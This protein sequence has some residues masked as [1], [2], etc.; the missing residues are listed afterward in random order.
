MKEFTYRIEDPHGLH[1]RPA[2]QLVTASK[3]FRSSVEVVYGEKTADAKRLLSL[4]TLGA[5]GG[6]VLRFRII[7]EDEAEAARALEQFCRLEWMSERE[8]A[9][10]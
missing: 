8:G 10:Q 6:G 1:A 2:G 7:G 5:I 4:M 9:P 3:P